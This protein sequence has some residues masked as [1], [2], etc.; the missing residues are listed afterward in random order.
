MEVKEKVLRAL[1]QFMARDRY[2]LAVAANERSLTHRLAI[3]IEQEFPDYNV[4]CEFQ[5]DGKEL[6]ILERFA[7]SKAPNSGLAYPD[8]IVHH[9]GTTDNHVVVETKTSLTHTDCGKSS[10][11][12]CDQCKLWA[13]RDELG[14]RH[15]FYVVFPFAQE[16]KSF[17]FDQ[18][19]KHLIEVVANP[20][21][22]AD[23]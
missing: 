5:K 13:Y 7:K 10:A 1:R 23:K 3:Y 16:L 4:D 17:S 18:I 19:E 8:I 2:L 22:Q 15:A 6:K 21:A 11:C 12:Y 14:Y 9:R 20:E